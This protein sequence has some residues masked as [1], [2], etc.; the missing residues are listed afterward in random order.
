MLGLEYFS[1]QAIWSP[2]FLLF[3]LLIAGLY[4]MAIGPWRKNI[5]EAQAVPFMKQFSFVTGMLMLYLAQGG[6]LNLLGH[7]TFTGHMIAMAVS[8]LLAPPLILYG[9]PS[10]LLRPF[11]NDSWFRFIKPML[12]P[13]ITMLAFNA[14]FSVYHIPLVH[15]FVMTNIVVHTLYYFALLITAFMLWWP[16]V[17]P[18]PEMSSLTDLKKLGYMFM[19]GVLLTPACAL[20][21]FAPTAMYG[22]FTDPK[23]WAQT[24]AYCVPGGSSGVLSSFSGP[25][26]F[27]PLSAKD[28]QQLGGVVMK[29]FQEVIY[30]VVL[31]Y[32]F[33]QWFRKENHEDPLP[34]DEMG[35]DELLEGS[36]NRA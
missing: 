36:L 3:M 31:F 1:Y 33:A 18:L 30:G 9:L 15:D 4:F 28:D 8:F 22:T 24:M 20:I 21:I 13:L 10:W 5:H 14:L 26:L 12:H 25:S 34:D 32:I 29:L 2:F 16:V 23:L 35:N 17:E 27:T 7:L 6:P 19:N 11:V